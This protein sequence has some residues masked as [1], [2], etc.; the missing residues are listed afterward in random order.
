M[1]YLCADLKTLRSFSVRRWADDTQRIRIRIPLPLD[2]DPAVAR[3]LQS[4]AV[5]GIRKW[6]R[7]P[8]LLTVDTRARSQ[9]PAD[10]VVEWSH[11]L[12]GNQL[13]VT[14]SRLEMQGDRL[15]LAVPR[16]ALATR[17]PRN[18]SRGL[19]AGQVFLTAAYSAGLTAVL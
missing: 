12:G 19:D 14:V 4:A 10:I 5:R 1:G 9:A 16:L 7:K 11:Q 3:A 18:P 8:F 6:D 15:T 13:G 17:S 2:E